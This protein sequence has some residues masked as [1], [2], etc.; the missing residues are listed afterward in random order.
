MSYK[1]NETIICPHCHASQKGAMWS[2]VTASES[3][4][5]KNKIINGTAFTRKCKECGESFALF[6]PMLYDDDVNN[7][8]IYYTPTVIGE[9]EA[10]EAISERRAETVHDPYKIRIVT[11]ADHLREKARI[12]DVGL[13]D[14]IVEIIKIVVLEQLAKKK[15]AGKV[16]DVLCWV[17]GDRSLE[18]AFFGDKSGTMTV[19][20]PFYQYVEAKC[21]LILNAKSDNVNNIDLNWAI[22]FLDKNNFIL[23]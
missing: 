11:S 13:D 3:K 14:R 18:M 7:A 9:L 23:N 6:Y 17:N 19:D 22:E 21:K 4:G 15:F 2:I 20:Y 1:S 8:L 12:F 16:K 5:M 10:D